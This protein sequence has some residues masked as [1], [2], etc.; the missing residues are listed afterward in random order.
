MLA[1]RCC[2]SRHAPSPPPPSACAGARPPPRPGQCDGWNPAAHSTDD[3]C[4]VA[5]SGRVRTQQDILEAYYERHAGGL[6]EGGGKTKAEIA[7]T[8]A[9]RDD[10]GPFWFPR[11]CAALQKKYGQEVQLA[12][13]AA[14][15][16]PVA[17]YRS[18]DMYV[19]SAA[20]RWADYACLRRLRAESATALAL[21]ARHCTLHDCSL[22]SSD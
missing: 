15:S 17:V 13:Y 2:L 11:L 20:P 19:I 16:A 3:V 9:R 10:G 18:R 5:C 12:G 1:C 21:F 14:A 8:L 7:S 6:G 22:F 4:C